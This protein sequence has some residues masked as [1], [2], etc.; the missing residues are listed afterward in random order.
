M[1]KKIMLAANTAWYLANFRLNLA[2]ALK[3]A[4]YEVVAVAPPGEDMARFKTNGIRFLPLPMDNKG[5]NP[6]VDLMLFLRLVRLLLRERPSGFLAY[7]PKPNVYGG[8]ACRLLGIPSIHTITGLGTAF[9]R[10]TWLSRLVRFL[11]WHGLRQAH[12]VFFQNRDDLDLFVDFG[13]V[14][15]ENARRLSGSGVDLSRFAPVPQPKHFDGSPFR[16]ILIARLL[17]DKGIGEYVAAARM[18]KAEGRHVEFD[19][20]GFLGVDN[21]TAIS[22]KTVSDWVNEGSVHYLGSTED[23]RPLIARADCVVLPSYR[24]GTPRS[25]LEAA[26]MGRPIVTTDSVGCREVIDDGETG[27]LCRPQDADDLGEKL[28]LMMDLTSERRSEMGRAGRAKM[29]SEFDERTVIER[30]LQAVKQLEH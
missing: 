24:E 11:Y 27:F 5:T 26:S 22:E 28:R 29:E 14:R 16:F 12:T 13:I 10:D 8:M 30:Y 23:V 17:W 3:Q 7:T 20:L 2:C 18:L 9:I 19:L 6:L 25:L 4:G 21:P 1:T 15:A